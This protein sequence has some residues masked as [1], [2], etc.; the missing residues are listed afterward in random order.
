VCNSTV[1]RTSVQR[2]LPFRVH[3]RDRQLPQEQL[4]GRDNAEAS[5][6]TE[7][8][9]LTCCCAAPADIRFS[10]AGRS[11][12]PVT[13]SA[14]FVARHQCA[15]RQKDGGYAVLRLLR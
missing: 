1:G 15:N 2:W 3:E 11:A 10:K 13:D 14:P 6:L 12:L 9:G 4:A 5:A 8:Q 7:V